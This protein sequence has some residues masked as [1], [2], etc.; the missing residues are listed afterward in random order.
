MK[1]TFSLSLGLL[2]GRPSYRRSLLISK[3]FSLFILLWVI[4]D[5]LD[6][7][8]DPAVHPDPQHCWF[9]MTV[10]ERESGSR[11]AKMTLRNRKS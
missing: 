6:I 7:D 10:S 3:Y 5:L 1:Y 4:L 11:R 8:P 2:K 9:K